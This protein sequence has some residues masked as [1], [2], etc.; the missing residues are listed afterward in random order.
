MRGAADGLHLGFDH[1]EH[2]F[3]GRGDLF[4]GIAGVLVVA[5]HLFAVLQ[6]VAAGLFDPADD[7][8]Q[9]VDKTV[10]PAA[11]FASLVRHQACGVQPLAE[12][13]FAFGYIA[14]DLGHA[15]HAPRQFECAAAPEPQGAESHHAEIQQAGS[16]LPEARVGNADLAGADQQHQSQKL[17]HQAVAQ[18]PV[19]VDFFQIRFAHHAPTV[20]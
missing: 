16:R 7:G 1:A 6:G 14:D 17:F 18:R 8:I 9:I 13:A 19:A 11:H 2:L 5:Q 12:I 3:D 4:G 20:R 10:G 15:A